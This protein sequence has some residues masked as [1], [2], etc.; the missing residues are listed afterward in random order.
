MNRRL[1]KPSG[2]DVMVAF[3]NGLSLAEWIAL[4]ALAKQDLRESIAYAEPL[5]S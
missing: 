3:L 1:D 5:A 2:E 4:P